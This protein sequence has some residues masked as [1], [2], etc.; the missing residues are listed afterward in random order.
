M[1]LDLEKKN[2][3]K[4]E[5]SQKN[6]KIKLILCFVNFDF[7]VLNPAGSFGPGGGVFFMREI[8]H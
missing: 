2:K 6:R 5:A 3:K 4:T 7:L 8:K 1:K